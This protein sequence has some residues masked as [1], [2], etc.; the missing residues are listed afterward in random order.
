[1]FAAVMAL[2]NKVKKFSTGGFV[3]GPGSSTF[4]SIPARL[5]A[6]EYVVRAEAV[7]RVGR[8]FLDNING[9]RS[10]VAWSGGAL[11]FAD[12][13]MVPE[14]EVPAGQ[15][16]ATTVNNAV[17]LHVYDDPQRIA[18]AA[19]NTKQGQDNFFVI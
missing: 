8:N 3:Y 11:A 12:G 4:N 1:M 16:K 15:S 9:L 2:I 13:G 7:C 18:D 17:N 14:I 5:S 6:G 19:F 10:G